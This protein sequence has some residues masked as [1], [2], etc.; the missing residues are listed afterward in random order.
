M[1]KRLDISENNVIRHKE[2]SDIEAISKKSY[3]NLSL[4]LR[5]IKS[6]TQIYAIALI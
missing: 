4:I 3:D 6:S 2:L 1:K 5:K